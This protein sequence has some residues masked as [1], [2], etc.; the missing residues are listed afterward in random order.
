MLFPQQHSSPPKEW[1]PVRGF[2]YVFKTQSFCHALHY[3]TMTSLSCWPD[4]IKAPKQIVPAEWDS[5]FFTSSAWHRCRLPPPNTKSS[6]GDFCPF[7]QGIWQSSSE[8]LHWPQLC[9]LPAPIQ[10]TLPP[11][12]SPT[13]ELL[14]DHLYP[15]DTPG[16]LQEGKNSSAIRE[17]LHTVINIKQIHSNF[18]SD[19]SLPISSDMAFR[20]VPNLAAFPM[21]PEHLSAPIT[22]YLD[23]CKSSPLF[24]NTDLSPHSIHRSTFSFFHCLQ[25]PPSSKRSVWTSEKYHPRTLHPKT[26]V[27]FREDILVNVHLGLL[28]WKS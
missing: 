8:L 21:T 19:G 11:L 20:L 10:A 5:S 15:S 27:Q 28:P 3:P 23:T 25:N 2:Y 26:S 7:L 1:Q 4:P 22:S 13:L 6:Q 9:Q 12:G 17:M 24:T 14:R 18:H 16:S